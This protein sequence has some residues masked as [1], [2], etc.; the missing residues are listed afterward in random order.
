M[1]TQK[2]SV[3]SGEQLFSS[4]LAISIINSRTSF[5]NTDTTRFDTKRKTATLAAWKFFTLPLKQLKR[6]GGVCVSYDELRATLVTL[7]GQEA[8]P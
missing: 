4:L 8:V 6:R 1:G 5:E 2:L 7:V 3:C